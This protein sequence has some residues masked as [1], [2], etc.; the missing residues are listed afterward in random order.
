MRLSVITT[1]ICALLSAVPAFGASSPWKFTFEGYLEDAD[2]VAVDAMKAFRFQMIGMNG[3]QRC[4]LYDETQSVKVD[5]G[6]FAAHVGDGTRVNGS[7]PGLTLQQIYG[8]KAISLASVKDDNGAA[9]ASFDPVNGE[10]YVRVFVDSEKIGDVLVTRAPMATQ[11]A[12]AADSDKVGGKAAT[13]LIQVDAVKNVTQDK[14]VDVFDTLYLVPAGKSARWNSSTQKFEAYDYAD[15]AQL[16]D[17][18]VPGSKLAD[19]SVSWDKLKDIPAPLSDLGAAS[20]AGCADGNVLKRVSGVWACATDSTG[21]FGG[22]TS[23]NSYL[24][25]GTGTT[26]PVLT[27]NVG[28]AANTVAAGDDSRFGNALKIQSAEIDTTG[29]ASGKILKYD[30][31]KWAVASD[32]AG[33]VATFDGLSP[34]TT[35]GDL[36]TRTSSTS[37]R[38]P[39]GADGKVLKADSSQATGL[40]W[41]DVVATDL[42]SM[43]STGIVQ[44]NGSNSYSS[45]TL[46]SPLTYTGGTLGVNVGSAS[47][48]VA[49]GDDGRFGNATRINDVAID[50]TALVANQ[51]LKYDGTKW[52]A[53]TDE[54]ITAE[55]DS[56][57][58]VWAKT[59]PGTGL[60]VSSNK[61]VPDF[62]TGSGK[63]AQGSDARFPSATCASGNYSRWNGSAWVCDSASATDSTKI[64]KTGD[65]TKNGALS[66]NYAG[67]YPLQIKNTQTGSQGT[68]LG[69]YSDDATVKNWSVG[70]DSYG[71]N[72]Y[73]AGAPNKYAMTAGS[74]GW[75]IMGDTN[76]RVAASPLHVKAANQTIAT[77]ESTSTNAGLSFRTPASTVSIYGNDSGNMVFYDGAGANRLEIQKAGPVS[78]TGDVAAAANVSVGSSLSVTGAASVAGNLAVTNGRIAS[79]PKPNSN[80]LG[81]AATITLDFSSA[82]TIRSTAAAGGP[83]GTLNV[84]N[85][86]AG[87]YHTFTL[88]LATTT[89]ATIQWNGAPTNVKVPS[90]YSSF[91]VTGVIY[92]FL[93]DG[94]TLWVSYVPF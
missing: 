90:G 72:I 67:Y 14:V 20:F 25:V 74:N 10:R 27:L 51:I 35:K 26:A 48:T 28:T 87:A 93:D 45:V 39:V 63:V 56:S 7:D 84:T 66:I 86:T 54:G 31:A 42:S 24:S 82:N 69:L 16:T 80:A 53:A 41:G 8:M 47:G 60:T 36:V 5:K 43:V 29:L 15:G 81:S 23:A 1:L 50:V 58:A 3:S 71:F 61:I 52:V 22:V 46:A 37:V 30:G 44:R 34:M 4:V 65:D 49:A 73:Y 13:D 70:T 91:G 88:P 75:T 9:C 32:D 59:T 76:A 40:A 92:T 83:C 85:T 6:N 79:T 17:A 38:L 78:L 68:W 55:T 21:S 12:Q 18:S 57:V 77:F 19:A 64:S 11:A 33:T 89:C 94:A 2:G 62:G